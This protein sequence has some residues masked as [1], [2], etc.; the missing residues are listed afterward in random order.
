VIFIAAEDVDTVIESATGIAGTEREQ[1][2]LVRSG[3]SL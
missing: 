2:R 1:A 3:T